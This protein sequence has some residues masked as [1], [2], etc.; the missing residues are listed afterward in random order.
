MEC[1]R[2]E[3]AR[4]RQREGIKRQEEGLSLGT[5]P[6]GTIM[7]DFIC[8]SG[9]PVG[10]TFLSGLPGETIHGSVVNALHKTA[11]GVRVNFELLD[12]QGRVVERVMVAVFPGTLAP[13][14]VGEFRVRLP[15]RAE[16]SKPWDCVRVVVTEQDPRQIE[17]Q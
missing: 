8:P 6:R 9:S 15:H 14:D 2:L 1:E 3:A 10:V 7:H 13:L 4:V 5:S 11:H 12:N 17:M 16:L